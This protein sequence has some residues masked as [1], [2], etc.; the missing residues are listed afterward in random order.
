MTWES[1]I[2]DLQDLYEQY[3][4]KTQWKKSDVPGVPPASRPW[5][6]LSEEMRDCLSNLKSERMA[7]PPRPE[8]E[9]VMMSSKEVTITGEAAQPTSARLRPAPA[10]LPAGLGRVIEVKAGGCPV[11]K[12]V[13]SS[14]TGAGAVKGAPAAAS[15]AHS[16]AGGHGAEPDGPPPGL[17]SPGGAAAAAGGPAAGPQPKAPA[18]EDKPT[19][20]GKDKECKQS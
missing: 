7:S 6:V 9:R 14:M 15:G 12:V 16:P 1:P 3:V 4:L 2:S 8:K 19:G 11:A 5:T 20:Q 18:R 10:G 17:P 13:P